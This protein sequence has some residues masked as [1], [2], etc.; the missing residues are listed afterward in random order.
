V[1]TVPA[2]DV[3]TCA[4][5]ATSFE[6]EPLV[7][8]R[9]DG[10]DVVRCPVCGLLFR[11]L[12]PR[13]EELEAIYDA[14]YFFSTAG[15]THG[16]GYSDYVAEEELHRE[17]AARRLEALAGKQAPGVLLDVGAAAG[18]FVDE[19]QRR[20]WDAR[21]IDIAPAMVE[22]GR[23]NLGVRL[24][25][26]S[27]GDAPVE[28]G[29]LD[30]VTMWD[31]IEHS[32]EPVADLLR[33]HELLRPGGVLALSTGDAASLIARI[34]GSRWHL[35][36]P[37]HHNFFFTV[38]TLC[39]LLDRTG[40]DVVEAAHPGARYSLRYLMHKARTFADI[41]PLRALAD[42]VGGSRAG[43]IKIPLNLYDIVTIC[44]VRR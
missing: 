3:V 29:T 13:K 24:E 34:S 6:P 35:L 22:W 19:A 44:A 31:Y 39:R 16:Q 36:T 14:S 9:K 27:L 30:V 2:A 21:G 12:L 28:P 1:T 10:F 18:L 20:G 8:F 5:C 38:P 40:F 41:A 23:E 11:A 33:A 43:G 17:V 32:I 26:A 42:A 15:D 4:A 7:K 37:R 25:L